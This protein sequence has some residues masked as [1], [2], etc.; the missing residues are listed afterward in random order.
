ME[1]L[2]KNLEKDIRKIIRGEEVEPIREEIGDKVDIRLVRMIV[3]SLQEASTGY[4]SALRF[5]GMKLGKKIGTNSGKSEISLVLDEIKTIIE[6]LDGGEVEIKISDTK[7]EASLL[8]SYCYLGYETPD[9]EHSLCYFEEGFI[10]GYIEG[11]I[12]RLGSLAVAEKENGVTKVNVDE[13]KC[14]G[15]GDEICEF[16]I[17]FN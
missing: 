6:A 9:T 11:V 12:N 10:E 4:K 17:R 13:V 5:A 1:K 16:V 3:F 2:I 15:R 7:R 14:Y 8:V